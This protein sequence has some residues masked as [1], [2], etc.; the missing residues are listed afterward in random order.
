MVSDGQELQISVS[1]HAITT[2]NAKV[3]ILSGGLQVSW[4]V[5]IDPIDPNFYIN[6]TWYYNHKLQTFTPGPPL[7]E[8]RANH[9][10]ATIIDK[11]TKATI[12]VVTGGYNRD[13]GV[14]INS[15]EMLIGGQW[16]S[17]IMHYHKLGEPYFVYFSA[18]CLK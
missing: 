9:G 7:L 5:S 6:Q 2:V 16:Q 1:N 14:K 12:P 18:I 11:K 13:Y 15:T 17:G 8:G 4:N 3:S 10:S